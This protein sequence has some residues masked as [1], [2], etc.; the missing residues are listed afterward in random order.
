LVDGGVSVLRPRFD[1]GC[2]DRRLLDNGGRWL[3]DRWLLDDW[4]LDYCLLD[5][6]LLDDWLLDDCL[7]DNWL[8]DDGL[9]D[10]WL[11]DDWPVDDWLV[12]DRGRH[13]ADHWQHEPDRVPDRVTDPDQGGV[14]EDLHGLAAVK[15]G[16]LPR[17]EHVMHRMPFPDGDEQ[18]PLVAVEGDFFAIHFIVQPQTMLEGRK[19]SHDLDPLLKPGLRGPERRPD[20]LASV[21]RD[22]SGLRPRGVG[23]E[24]EFAGVQSQQLEEGIRHF[25]ASSHLKAA[26]GPRVEPQAAAGSRPTNVEFTALRSVDQELKHFGKCDSV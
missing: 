1:L 3:L 25:V 4:L 2:P 14:H 12:D 17:G 23:V 24:R 13:R 16:K 21:R 7:H 10:D 8:L 9:L 26:Q 6:W 20:I 11:H 22:L 5:D 15:L 18:R 19:D